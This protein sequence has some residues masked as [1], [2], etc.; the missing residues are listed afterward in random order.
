MLRY[1]DAVLN[2]YEESINSNL[3][4]IMNL[5]SQLKIMKRDG[6]KDI[7]ELSDMLSP[8]TDFSDETTQQLDEKLKI[9][10]T[11]CENIEKIKALSYNFTYDDLTANYNLSED[12]LKAN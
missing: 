4:P 3:N 12:T 2:K 6:E 8:Q 9:I 10:Q 11:Y 1:K 5:K 7:S